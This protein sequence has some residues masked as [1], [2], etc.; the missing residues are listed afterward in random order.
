VTKPTTI[1]DELS[2]FQTKFID[3]SR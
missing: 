3:I 1:Q 2:K